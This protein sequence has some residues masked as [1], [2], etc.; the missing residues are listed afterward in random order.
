MSGPSRQVPPT[1]RPPTTRGP[2]RYKILC[3]LLLL[4]ALAMSV[5]GYLLTDALWCYDPD[6]F[7]DG[8]F[9][10]QSI[11]RRIQAARPRGDSESASSLPRNARRARHLWRRWCRR[12]RVAAT[13]RL[14]RGYSEGGSMSRAVS[15][16]DVDAGWVPEV[17]APPGRATGVPGRRR[18][19][20]RG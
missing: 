14:S 11:S 19:Q 2:A 17:A 20:G 12:G 3:K 8:V 7:L 16:N 18:G 15:P 5:G 9:C 13:P 1:A 6:A 4:F 10:G